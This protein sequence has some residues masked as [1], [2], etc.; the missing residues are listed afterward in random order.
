MHPLIP[1]ETDQGN[2][3]VNGKYTF[4]VMLTDLHMFNSIINNSLN[5]FV[6]NVIW[7]QTVE[8]VFTAVMLN[9]ACSLWLP[10]SLRFKQCLYV[11]K[12]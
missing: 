6:W 2:D 9:A 7:A 3:L 5:V 10:A 11:L 8:T 12:L 1:R 4:K